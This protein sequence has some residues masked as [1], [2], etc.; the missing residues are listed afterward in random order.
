MSYKRF[1]P[2]IGVGATK[3]LSLRVSVAALVRVL[4]ENPGDGELILAL[5]RKATILEDGGGRFVDVKAQPFGGALQ[6]RDP[7]KLQDR[8]GDYHFDSA[9]SR[10]AQDFRIFIQPSAWKSVQQFC[11]RHFRHGNDLV[12]ESDPRREL[13]EEFAD[14]M[15]IS[16]NSDQLSY[17][18]VGMVIEQAPSPTENV[19]ARGSPTA[20]IYR[21]F[22]ARILDPSL[23]DGMLRNSAQFSNQDLQK[24][25]FENVQRGERG[26]VNTVLTLFRNQLKPFYLA[27]SPETRN[28][29][30]SFH[31]HRLDETVAAILENVTV[32]KYQKL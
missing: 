7:E 11:L 20:R 30:V 27:L 5:E 17:K 4:F 12:L 14:A 29:P 8:I 31:E 32:P 21:I 22:E 16:L 13:V 1:K 26:W 23:A 25:A 28:S 24:L 9:Q 18:S 2:D 19:Y 15:D 10:S 3:D 6:I